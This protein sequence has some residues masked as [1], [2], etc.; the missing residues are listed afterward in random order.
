MLYTLFNISQYHES[1]DISPK[2]KLETWDTILDESIEVVALKVPPN[3]AIKK[4]KKK[5]LPHESKIANSQFPLIL[6]F[7][8]ESTLKKV[9]D[10]R[11]K[12]KGNK[13]NYEC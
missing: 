2:I 13:K 1:I 9:K 8:Q 11:D 5:S 10:I 6:Q 4:K 3:V 7:K 12:E